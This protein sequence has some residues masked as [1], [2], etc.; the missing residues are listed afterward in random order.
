MDITL[1]QVLGGYATVLARYRRVLEQRNRLLHDVASG[2]QSPT[3]IDQWDEQLAE[4]GQKIWEDRTLIAAELNLAACSAHLELFDSAQERLELRYQRSDRS[5]AE[6]LQ[7]N[8]GR[9]IALRHT[10]VGPHR[11]DLMVFVNGRP[12]ARFASQGQQRCAAVAIRLG[13][14]ILM[15]RRLGMS[16]VML[17][18]DVMS[19]LDP[20]RRTSLTKMVAGKGQ[21]WITGAAEDVFPSNCLE[22]GGRRWKVVQGSIVDDQS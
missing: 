3:T 6:L 5:L 21:V 22:M 14:R 4:L 1:I 13:E 19:E 20:I 2:T 11:D 9:D 18:D 10:S 12:A 16:P 17:L 15:E 7:L 8:R